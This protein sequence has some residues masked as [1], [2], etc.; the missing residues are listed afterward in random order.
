MRLALRISS[1]EVTSFAEA[2]GDRSPLHCEQAY[3]RRTPFVTPVAH[4]ALVVWSCLVGT[5]HLRGG[6]VSLNARFHAP[7]YP[8]REYDLY[9][10]REGEVMTL[11]VR[12]GRRALASTTVHMDDSLS[13][14]DAHIASSASHGSR[15]R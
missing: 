3:A 1:A 14:A 10:V 6:T 11:E 7:V 9:V 2:S 5:A 15:N 12:D 13:A 8:D 4:G